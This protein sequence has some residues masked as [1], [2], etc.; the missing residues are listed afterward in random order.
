MNE[1]KVKIKKLQKNA[2]IPTY[3]MKGDAGMDLTAVSE[4]VL[5][6]EH[7]EYKFGIAIEIPK[8]YVGLLFLRFSC[9]KQR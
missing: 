4:K 3:S 9:Y 7:T 2:I 5:D 6:S 1:L 8:G